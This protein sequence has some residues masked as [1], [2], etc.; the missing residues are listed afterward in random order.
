M[1]EIELGVI[2][3]AGTQ[4]EGGITVIGEKPRRRPFCVWNVGGKEYRLKLTTAMICQLEN[5]YKK[6]L[7]NCIN[8]M[9]PL[10]TMLTIVQGAMQKYHHGISYSKVQDIYD[11]YTDEGGN[12]TDFFTDVVIEVLTVSGFFTDSQTEDVS[13]KMESL[14]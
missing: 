6:N 10:S 4:D 1:S 9:P 11:E 13:S 2:E 14:M 12:Q 8:E 3:D 7:L 5:K